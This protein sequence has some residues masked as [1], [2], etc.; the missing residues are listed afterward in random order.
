M[1]LIEPHFAPPSSHLSAGQALTTSSKT[2]P[3]NFIYSQII[4]VRENFMQVLAA[5]RCCDCFTEAGSKD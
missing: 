4:Q 2:S 3:K 5:P 1:Q